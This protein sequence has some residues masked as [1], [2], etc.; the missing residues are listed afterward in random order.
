MGEKGHALVRENYAFEKVG[1][2]YWQLYE[3]TVNR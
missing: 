1:V 3:K 2:M